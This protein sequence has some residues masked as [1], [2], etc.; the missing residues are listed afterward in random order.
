M[1][2]HAIN[3]LLEAQDLTSSEDYNSDAGVIVNSTSG[4][5]SS[6]CSVADDSGQSAQEPS[7]FLCQFTGSMELQAD[8]QTVAKYLDAHRGWFCRCAR[9]MKVEPLND[10]GYT[11]TIGRLG[12]FGYEVE[13]SIS[14]ALLPQEEGIYRIQTISTPD[15]DSQGYQVDFQAALGLAEIPLNSQN[16]TAKMLQSKLTRVEWQLNLALTIQFPKFIHKLPKPLVQRTGNRLLA[17]VV[18]Q[19]SQRLTNKVEEDFHTAL[20]LSVPKS[21]KKRDFTSQ[22]LQASYS[23]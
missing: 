19:V 1:Q 23:Y 21:R 9:P 14:L 16:E 13:P 5:V 7:Q 20:G 17:K 8:A 4:I 22:E 15:S 12:A 11:L 18:Q 3:Q 10:N 6:S 2:S